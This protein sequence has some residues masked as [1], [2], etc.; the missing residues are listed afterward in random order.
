MCVVMMVQE[1]AKV[2]E[3][4]AAFK[5]NLKLWKKT[6]AEGKT[7]TFPVLSLLLEDEAASLSTS[8]GSIW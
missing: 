4:L 5:G 6:M 1:L 8:S 3:K 7:A 2:S